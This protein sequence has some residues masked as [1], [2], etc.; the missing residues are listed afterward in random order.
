MSV[1]ARR[2]TEFYVQYSAILKEGGTL[3]MRGL[4]LTWTSDLHKVIWSL[5]G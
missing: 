4:N 1:R 5:N 2:H 3:Q